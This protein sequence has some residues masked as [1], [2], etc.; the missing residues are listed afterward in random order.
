MLPDKVPPA[1]YAVIGDALGV[2]PDLVRAMATKESAERPDAIRFEKHWWRKLRFASREAKRHDR[3]G[4]ARD[5]G[6]R[7]IHFE[8]MDEICRRDAMLNPAADGAAIQSHSF[9]WCQIM[10]FNFRHCGFEEPRGFLNAMRTV[11]GQRE[12]FIALVRD[13]EK[14][15]EAMRRE[16]CHAIGYHFNGRNYRKNNYHIDIARLTSRYRSEGTAYA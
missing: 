11:Q 3:R 2:S 14:L 1:D 6:E 5:W 13:D 9:G 16:D 7:W 12:C 4:N 8:A 10:G 15:H